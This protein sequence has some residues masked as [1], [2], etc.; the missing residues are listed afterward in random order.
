MQN[1]ALRT[2]HSEF[3]T[4]SRVLVIGLDGATYDVLVPLAESGVMPNIAGLLRTSALATLR[5]TEPYT[6]PVAWT[7]FQT[8]GDVET[9]GIFD[10]RYLDHE[11][12]EVLLNHAGRI[13]CPTI[14]EEI[15]A[16]GGGV[17]SIDLPMTYPP[18]SDVRGIVVG[19]LDSP[20]AQT[21][22]APHPKLAEAL[23]AAG[24]DYDIKTI[25]KRK[26]QSY[27]ELECGVAKTIASF[28]A[29][30]TA[31]ELADGMTDWRL[32]VVQFQALDSL[33][34]RCWHLLGPLEH[35]A[36]D[37]DARWVAETHR[38]LR[39]LDDC[40]GKLL[41]LAG[42]RD[43]ATVAMSD[44]GFGDFRAK[45]SVP[46]VLRQRGLLRLASSWQS[47]EHRAA[48]WSWKLKKWHVRNFHG[49]S[50][51]AVRRPLAALAPIDW[52]R[53]LAFAVHGELS[54]LVYL[55]DATRFGSGSISMP[56]QREQ[57]E[58]DVIAA[59]QDARHPETGEPLFV[60]VYSTQRRFDCDPVSRHWPDVVAIPA[61]GFHTRTKFDDPG[62]LMLDDATLTGTHRREGVLMINA[63]PAIPGRR[64]IADMRDAAPTL[65]HLLGLPPAAHMTGRPLFNMLGQ[66]G[67]AETS[68]W[69]APNAPV[70]EP[71]LSASEQLVVEQRLRE[72]GYME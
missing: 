14:F 44:H 20:S 57:A 53:S 52:Q 26:P 39:A 9:H 7:S 10:Y 1:T 2:P 38:S 30:V 68:P 15:A 59:F 47:V 34:H 32:M 5:S 41:E 22:L 28:Q 25:W 67:V 49:C 17:V 69:H 18:R 31:A 24:V 61:P 40:V 12:G 19:G 48:R 56:R 11:R 63:P 33:Q 51:A 37:V 46:E 62:R 54:A 64:H 23:R 8:G 66:T 72:L 36:E 43:A 71:V 16:A 21:A 13:A 55:S 29:R 35:V 50:T 42:K 58:A 6:T 60:D 70:A 27:E 4:S 65:L 3:R 45:I